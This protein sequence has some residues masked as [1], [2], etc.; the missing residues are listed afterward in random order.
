MK[1]PN[2]NYVLSEFSAKDLLRQLIDLV[3]VANSKDAT[4]WASSN[5][6]DQKG[7]IPVRCTLDNLGKGTGFGSDREVLLKAVV[8]LK[9]DGTKSTQDDR[10]DSQIQA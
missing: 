8:P 7:K 6:S 4:G 3:D 9:L 5:H 1:M 2:I 10:W